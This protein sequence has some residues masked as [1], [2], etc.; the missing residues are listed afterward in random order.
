MKNMFR[1]DS[2]QLKSV[3]AETEIGK[4]S[5]LPMHVEL[6]KQIAA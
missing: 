3:P 5:K 6:S 2:E 4:G 1:I